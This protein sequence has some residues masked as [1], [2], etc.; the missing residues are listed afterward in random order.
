VLIVTAVVLLSLTRLALPGGSLL[1][2]AFGMMLL[3]QPFH[4]FVAPSMTPLLSPRAQAA[5]MAEKMENGF[6]P[7]AL[8]V[9]PG[10]YAW[11]LNEA[12][13]I[14][15][16]R[17]AVPD[18]ADEAA[19]H[20]W[21]AKNPKATVAMPKAVWEG[22]AAKPA[23]ASVLLTQWMVHKPYVVVAIEGAAAPAKAPEI[24]AEAAPAGS[25]PETKASTPAAPA[26]AQPEAPA[27]PAEPK[28]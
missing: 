5:V 8:G 17:H 24:P 14:K 25:A 21:L 1:V 23:N 7:A 9:Y 28:A 2:T 22:L 10:A 4:W 26:D 18:L 12:A 13:G 3:L 27:A 6:V 15:G 19:L 11:H 16:V 20:A